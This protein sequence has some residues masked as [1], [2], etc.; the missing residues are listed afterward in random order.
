MKYLFILSFLFLP[1]LVLA[2]EIDTDGDGI[3]DQLE[4]NRYYTDP[5]KADTDGDEFLDNDE[6][7]NGFSPNHADKRLIEVDLDND[8]LSD[9][10]ELALKTDIK[11]RDSDGDGFLDGHEFFNGYD[12]ASVEE[13][14][15]EKTIQLDLS[16]Q[17]LWYQLGPVILNKFIVSTGRPSLPTPTGE[18]KVENKIDLAFSKTYGLYMPYWMGIGRGYGIH[19]LPY[20]PGG[21]REGADHLGTP[22]SHGCIR[23]SPEGAEELFNWAEVGTKVVIND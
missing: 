9:G 11:N 23:L 15:L 20:W 1:S 12:P 4:L 21:F 8:G 13:V 6:L 3:L 7:I 17:R 10:Y 19:E 2:Q 18:F 22:V 14:K 5:F 16:E